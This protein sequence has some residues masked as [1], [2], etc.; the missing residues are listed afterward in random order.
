[1]NYAD[2]MAEQVAKAAPTPLT[3]ELARIA[4]ALERVACALEALGKR[5]G[6][7]GFWS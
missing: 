4:A 2:W 6:G 3:P 1:M 7:P 5:P